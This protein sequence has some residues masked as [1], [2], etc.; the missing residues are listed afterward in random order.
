VYSLFNEKGPVGAY[1]KKQGYEQLALRVINDAATANRSAQL[2]SIAAGLWSAAVAMEDPRSCAG[3]DAFAKIAAKS[4]EDGNTSLAMTLARCGTQS[5]AARAP[6]DA[7][8]TEI[9]ANLRKTAS[10]A[11]GKVGAVEIPVD[12]SNPAYPIYKSNAEFATG[13]FESAWQLYLA[14]TDQ[15]AA[16]LRSLP[17]NYAFWLLEK[18]IETDR[19]DEAENLIKELT[20]WSRQAE[21]TFSSSQDAELKI[22]YAD[23]AFRKGALPTARA[24]YRKVA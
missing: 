13:N 18:S 4:L 10:L 6:A 12:E 8:L 11:A 9:L 21:G 5:I 15:L 22:A 23:L 17:V 24:W 1:P 14:H 3:A 2:Q 20:I 16:V 7:K 19:S